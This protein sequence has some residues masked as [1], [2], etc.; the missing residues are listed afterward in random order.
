MKMRKPKQGPLQIHNFT[1][2]SYLKEEIQCIPDVNTSP[3]KCKKLSSI[4]NF[5]SE[6]N[7]SQL[8]ENAVVAEDTYNS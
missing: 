8:K 7:G 1:V 6:M 4:L 2:I 3:L 5:S